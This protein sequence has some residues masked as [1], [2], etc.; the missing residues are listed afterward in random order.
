MLV[1]R[2]DEGLPV[3]EKWRR[4]GG[5]EIKETRRW[6][7]ED[8]IVLQAQALPL[9]ECGACVR[10]CSA[11]HAVAFGVVARGRQVLARRAVHARRCRQGRCCVLPGAARHAVRLSVARRVLACAQTV[12]NQRQRVS[13]I[14]CN[15]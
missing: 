4:D 14:A 5:A 8:C 15:R 10:T 3:E 6:R 13:G 11:R 7:Y 1:S 9:L 12:A 2:F